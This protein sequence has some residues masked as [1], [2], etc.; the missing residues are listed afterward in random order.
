MGRAV[1]LTGEI[2]SQGIMYLNIMIN[3][4]N[5]CQKSPPQ[6]WKNAWRDKRGYHE[7]RPQSAESTVGD[8]S[9]GLVKLCEPP[10]IQWLRHFRSRSSLFLSSAEDCHWPNSTRTDKTTRNLANSHLESQ[11]ARENGPK[12]L[13]KI[14][15]LIELVCKASNHLRVSSSD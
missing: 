15:S 8:T 13:H 12:C 11:F 10:W 5:A 9:L 14:G 2:I 4:C 6:S 1:S 7:R 3:T